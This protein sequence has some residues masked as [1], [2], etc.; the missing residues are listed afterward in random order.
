MYRKLALPF[1][2]KQPME[3]KVEPLYKNSIYLRSLYAYTKYEVTVPK[4][5][6]AE[7]VMSGLLWT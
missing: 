6:G 4:K 5:G 2:A 1:I 3:A 7:R